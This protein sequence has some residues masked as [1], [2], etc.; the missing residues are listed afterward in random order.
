MRTIT[1]D[2]VFERSYNLFNAEKGA[3]YGYKNINVDVIHKNFILPDGSPYLYL[4]GRGN[5]QGNHFE[6]LLAKTKKEENGSEVVYIRLATFLLNYK[7]KEY[8]PIYKK[9]FKEMQDKPNLKGNNAIDPSNLYESMLDYTPN[10]QE[11]AHEY[12]LILLMFHHR[13]IL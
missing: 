5:G 4:V 10:R 11:D 2:R 12:S 3:E 1:F 8:H 6:Y 7:F 9:L 13:K